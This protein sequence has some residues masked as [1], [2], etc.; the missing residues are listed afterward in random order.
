MI[1]REGYVACG[2]RADVLPERPRVVAVGRYEVALFDV[3]G[4][5]YA[6]E[7]ACPHQGGPIGEGFIEGS[8]VTC[9]WHAWCFDLRTGSMTIGDFV[10]LRRFAA[11]VDGG[12]VY[13]APEPE[14]EP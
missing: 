3:G 1:S 5:L 12:V 8:T 2:R 13:V 6:Y 14:A 4:E 11:Y 7:N 10:R 9:P